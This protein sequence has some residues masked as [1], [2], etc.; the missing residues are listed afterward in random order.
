MP[1]QT[2]ASSASTA[3]HAGWARSRSGRA[4]ASPGPP[5]HSGWVTTPHALLQDLAESGVKVED[6][7]EV[8]QTRQRYPKSVPVLIDWLEHLGERVTAGQGQQRLREALVRSL[9]TPDARPVAAPLLIR[10]MVR[11]ANAGEWAIAWAAGNGLAVVSD[12]TVYEDVKRLAQDQSLGKAREMLA[13]ALARMTDPD[14]TSTLVALLSDPDVS[15]HAVDALARRG[16]AAGIRFLKPFTED[17]RAWVRETARHALA[18]L[19]PE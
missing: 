12:D 15:G 11:A 5:R 2:G 6:I 4:L 8:V 7:W 1:D 18:K 3:S 17:K 9:T 13:L 10:E 14:A 19:P 16:D